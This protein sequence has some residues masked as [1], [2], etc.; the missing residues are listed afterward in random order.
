MVML[1][2]FFVNFSANLAADILIGIAVY[3]AIT[4]PGEKKA[5]QKRLEQAL[6]LLKAE[7]E[8]NAARA[9]AY[10]EKISVYKDDVNLDTLFP[11]RF[12]RGAWNALKESGF[13]PQLNDARL[14]YHLLQANELTVVA[15]RSLSKYRN[16][17]PDDN[18]NIVAITEKARRD[19]QHLLL[20]LKPL[21]S[22]LAKMDL[23]LF[24]REEIYEAD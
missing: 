17:L 20:A 7:L 3:L 22:I 4:Q 14:V 8:I 13:L 12:T 10:I 11:F 16:A 5:A 19:C 1:N 21:I 18:E 2:E 23:P 15:N 6:G 24:S 9:N